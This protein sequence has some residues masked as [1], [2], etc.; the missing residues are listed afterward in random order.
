MRKPRGVADCPFS[1]KIH[2][3]VNGA[4]NV[5]KQVAKK[6]VGALSEPLSFLVICNGVTPLKGGNAQDPGRTLAL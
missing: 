3:D 4:L 6:I 2:S 1:H 5:V